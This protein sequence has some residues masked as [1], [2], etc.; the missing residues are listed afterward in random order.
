MRALP[1]AQT[2]G[3]SVDLYVDGPVLARGLRSVLIRSLASICGV[4]DEIA[5]SGTTSVTGVGE[6][7]P[8]LDNSFDAVI[9]RAVPEHVRDPFRCA[10]GIA[11]ILK[12]G[13]HLKMESS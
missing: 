8:F 13:G 3:P 6:A 5:G 1:G 2:S 12:P 11:R 4:N 7:L 10:A 9:S